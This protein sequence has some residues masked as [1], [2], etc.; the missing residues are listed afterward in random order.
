MEMR[1]TYRIALMAGDGVGIDVM[2]AAQLVLD[3]LALN[4]E[5]IPIDVGWTCWCKEGNALPKRSIKILKECDCALFGAV[6]SKPKNKA[7]KELD[8]ELRGKGVAYK[9]P[10]VEL[11]QLFD[12]YINLRPCKA[13]TGNPL[14]YRDDID[15]VIFRENT[16]GLYSGVELFPFPDDVRKTISTHNRAMLKFSDVPSDEIA[17]SLRVITK[18]GAH[19]IVKRAFEFAQSFGYNSVTLVEKPNI[20]RET[21]GLMCRE[22]CLVAAEYPDIELRETNIDA[23][24]M[25]LVKNPDH[26]GVI[27]TSNMFGDIVSDL[28]AQLVGGLGFAASGNLGDDFAI[29][30]PSHGSVPKYSGQ[31]KVNPTAMLLAVKLMLDWLGEKDRATAL[32]AAIASVIADGKVKTY[33]MGGMA[34]TMDMAEAVIEKF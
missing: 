10:I 3:R 24:M 5:Y 8:L 20:L 26:Y 34:S 9:S 16:E 1:T 13:Y 28:A 19:R 21:S 22:A 7:E 25:W 2:A 31:Y 17:V 32:D 27:V 30:E 14:N 11:R 29:F 18:K 6:T 4:A 12:L 23:Q 15:M 33:D